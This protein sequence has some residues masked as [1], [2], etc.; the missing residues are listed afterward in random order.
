[1]KNL[2]DLGPRESLRRI[3][4]VGKEAADWCAPGYK[5]SVRFHREIPTIQILHPA[6][7]MRQPLAGQSLLEKRCVVILSKLLDEV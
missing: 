1:L 7:I 2:A 6:Y 3:V 5:L 4:L